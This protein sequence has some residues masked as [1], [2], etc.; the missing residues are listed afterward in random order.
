[1]K[2]YEIC[3]LA[4]LVAWLP[5]AVLAQDVVFSPAA[6]EQCLAQAPGSE[7]SCIGASAER[8]MTETQGGQSTYG[9]SACLDAEAGYWDDRLNAAYRARMREAKQADADAKAGGWTPPQQED[10]LRAMQRAWIA[11]RDARCSY[12]ASLWSGGTGA[13][14]AAVGC[15]MQT[16]GEQAL[17]LENAGF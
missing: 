3:L 14:P 6:T 16:T 9:M 15:F 5:G 7:A 1:M 4:N 11:F 12:A 17:Y 10:A 2:T 13:G 8:C